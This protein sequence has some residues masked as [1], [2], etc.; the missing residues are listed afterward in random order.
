MGAQRRY[1]P[2]EN[3]NHPQCRGSPMCLNKNASKRKKYSST[4]SGPTGSPSVMIEGVRRSREGVRKRRSLKEKTRKQSDSTIDFIAYPLRVLPLYYK[5]EG[6]FEI[7]KN[8]SNGRTR[9]CAPT[10]NNRHAQCR[11]RPMCL[12]EYASK[13][14]KYSST[15]SGPTGSP[16]VMIEGVRRSREGV[17]KRR[18]L[19]E[20]TR[21]QSDSTI[22]FIAYPLRVLPL[23][24]KK[25]GEFKRQKNANNGRTRRCAP[26]ENNNQPQCRGRPMCLPEYA[27]KKKKYS[28]TAS[29]PTGSPS[30][31][32]EE[33][34]ERE[35]E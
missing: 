4:A 22:D 2:T 29:G 35:E 9:R 16:S 5:K 33:E 17:R 8:A 24:Y 26:T 1:A 13:R 15:A 12:P 23:Y 10:A 3:N 18:S 31:M 21:K 14:K 32:I 28:S 20:K 27:S 19:K 11:G 6:E 7:Q 25:E 34:F 30:V